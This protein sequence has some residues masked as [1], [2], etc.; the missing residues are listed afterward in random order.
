MPKEYRIVHNIIYIARPACR[1]FFILAW[2]AAGI[3]G[4]DSNG[5]VAGIS[6]AP[7]I[8]ISVNDT[9]IDDASVGAAVDTVTAPPDKKYKFALIL[10][11][12][13]SRGLAQIGAL[14][15]LEE[16]GL[17]PDLIVASSMGS[18]VGGLYACGYSPS[19]ILS[20]AKSV[21]WDAISAP[22]D[23]R[24]SLFVSQKSSPKGHLLEVR[25]GDN[26]RPVLPNAIV[27]GQIFYTLL[28]AK[29][30]PAL[31][32]A[33]YDFARLPVSLRVAATDLL[34]GE[35]VIFSEG[36]LPMAIRASCGAPL[37]FSPLD[38]DGKMLIDGGLSANIPVQA[39]LDAGAA[40]TVAIDV[41][42]PLWGREQL[43]DSP[44]RLMEQIAS[45]GVAQNKLADSR[46]ADVLIRPALGA[47]AN[48]D[49][50]RI[51]A[52][53]AAGYAAAAAAAP[54]IAAR[55]GVADAGRTP[56]DAPKPA[57]GGPGGPVII[58]SVTDVR[59]TGNKISSANQTLT[60]SGI[61]T[62]RPLDS[63]TV[64][65]AIRALHSTNLFE[66]V[67]IETTLQDGVDIRVDEKRYWRVRG[68]LRYDEYHLGEGFI[69]PAYENL[70]G[71]GLTAALH[72][73]YGARNE[74]YAL[75]I[76]TNFLF[77][78][79]WAFNYNAQ[80]FTAR[81]RI[82]S[83][84]EYQRFAPDSTTRP[85][86]DSIVIHDEVLGK[87]GVA[88]VAG[89]Q[90]G[91]SVSM[92]AGAKL[93]SFQLLQSNRGIFDNDL[94]FGFRNS[95]PYFFLRLNID[96]RDLAPFT[97]NGW[98]HIVTAGM[99]GGK[100][101]GLG[102][103]DEF[104]KVDGNFNR[105][106]TLRKRH[107]LHGQLA[108]GWT[109]SE[110]PDVEKFYLGGAI[111]EQNYRDAQIYNIVPFMGLKPRSVSADI[112]GLA[113]IEYRFKAR[114]NLYVSAMADWARLWAYEDFVGAGGGSESFPSKNPLGAGISAAYST[115]LG[116]IRASYGQLIPYK[117]APGA[118]PEAVFYFSAGYDF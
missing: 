21:D 49:F 73:Q 93:E 92:E 95:L 118:A 44:V 43:L 53:V 58:P 102:G 110:L 91:K 23:A 69:E 20:I 97:E 56:S 107:T 55:L 84:E 117:Y 17:K 40:F 45:I 111:P 9:S 86:P 66:S 67:R 10:S 62:G 75:G 25:L 46:S 47:A 80:V 88:F 33:G 96:T 79:N 78:Q 103:I 28:T 105:Y 114:K 11:G 51:D 3:A 106:V 57:G 48:T 54:E 65:R 77:T 108:T 38:F 52:L 24:S 90:I 5:G 68:G 4:Q 42:S 41:T 60:A 2:F 109:N 87:S 30:L 15:A 101:L 27:D 72:L 36:S 14:T 83:R 26:F 13:G 63:A 100:A 71:L 19:R 81:E 113:H 35:L 1:L 29:L 116:P 32:A 8:D 16:A 37:A 98:R 70:F 99:A 39:A 76:G 59:V 6:D 104:V 94:G 34:T 61:K 85:L 12:G 50:S 89:S 7:V 74:K 22:A 115:P 18:V 64:E 112:F 82:Y 31:H